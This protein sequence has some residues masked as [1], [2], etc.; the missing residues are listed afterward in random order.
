MYGGVAFDFENQLSTEQV[1][2]GAAT[3]STDSY[4]KQTAA[5]DISIGRRLALLVLP[6]L[7][8]ADPAATHTLQVIQADNAALTSNVEVL[9]TVTVL[10]TKLVLGEQVEV[11]IPQGVMTKQFIGFRHS[12]AGGTDNDATL[13]VYIMPQDEI[14]KYKTFP[15]VVDAK[16]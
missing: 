14:A 8:D 16:V 11:P 7:V 10:G 3:V 6:A 5:Q 12:A 4:Q 13:D 9:N 15:K 1:F 2:T